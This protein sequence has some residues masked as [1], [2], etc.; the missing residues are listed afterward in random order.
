MNSGSI[1]DNILVTDSVEEAKAHAE[2]HWAKITEGEKEANEAFDKKNEPP[3]SSDDEPPPSSDDD[4]VGD[5]DD[6]ED[7]DVAEDEDL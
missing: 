5:V 6:D 4:D 2:A 1:F 3:P 7:L